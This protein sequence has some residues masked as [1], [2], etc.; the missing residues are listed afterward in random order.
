MLFWETHL[1]LFL[2]EFGQ[3]CCNLHTKRESVED[4]AHRKKY[5]LRSEEKSSDLR[6]AQA[7]SFFKG[8]LVQNFF[9]FGC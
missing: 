9:Q 8:G 6:V 2:S 1:L 4:C 3:K 7:T 5:K